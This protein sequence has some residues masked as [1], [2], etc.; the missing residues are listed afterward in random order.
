MH[1]IEGARHIPAAMNSAAL[2]KAYS[3]LEA[4]LKDRKD[5]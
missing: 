4:E 1:T 2:D 3:F 5:P